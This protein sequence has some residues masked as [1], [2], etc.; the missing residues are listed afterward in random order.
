MKKTFATLLAILSLGGSA[1]SQ[2]NWGSYGNLT[3]DLTLTSTFE[4]L[5]LKDEIGKIL[6]AAEGGGP[7][8]SNTFSVVT[9]NS[10]DEEIKRVDTEE[11]GST[12]QV[13]RL[14][15]AQILAYLVDSQVLLPKGTKAPFI[16]GYSLV[17]VFDGE[18]AMPTVYVRH[19]DKS[20]VPLPDFM[21][22]G[23]EDFNLATIKRKFDTTTTT[24]PATSDQTVTESLTY[25]NS[26]KGLGTATVPTFLGPFECRGITTGSY[27]YFTKTEGA[28]IDKIT[29]RVFAPVSFNLD[30][31]IG[32]YSG[33]DEPGL[34]EGS[35]NIPKVFVTDLNVYVG[36]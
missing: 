7:T 22:G 26:Y 25:S 21:L 14:G 15:N 10:Q 19:S 29:T 33:G 4:S 16:A 31:T 20:M 30:K 35:F 12:R 1:F 27:K 9:L 2:A 24:N 11:F 13:S 36:Q 5:L 17:V 6:S 34:I 3:V 32:V 28:G 18:E 8:N 23:A